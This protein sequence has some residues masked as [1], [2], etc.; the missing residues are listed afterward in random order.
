MDNQWYD[1]E[2]EDV[3]TVLKSP[4]RSMEYNSCCL[5]CTLS[6]L[7]CCSNWISSCTPK[8]RCA[9]YS[10]LLPLVPI[11]IVLSPIIVL[12]L[13][14]LGTLLLPFGRCR[15]G[16]DDDVLKHMKRR[17]NGEIKNKT[18]EKETTSLLSPLSG[19]KRLTKLNSA[20]EPTNKTK[21]LLV[22]R[23]L[24]TMSE[25]SEAIANKFTP[26]ATP[27]LS[28][29]SISPTLDE[30]RLST[31][32]DLHV[33]HDSTFQLGTIATTLGNCYRDIG[34]EYAGFLPNGSVVFWGL[35]LYQSMLGMCFLSASIY[36]YFFFLLSTIKY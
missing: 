4:G 10:F 9:R 22:R 18:N 5:T 27:Q 33:F 23:S 17:K 30:G 31:L 2:W 29:V 14:I 28:N 7:T 8:N 21:E 1:F 11:L 15:S 20:K 13:I 25:S 12:L 3:R 35:M 32:L 16:T 36:F 34:G 6:C 24:R 19:G 26:A